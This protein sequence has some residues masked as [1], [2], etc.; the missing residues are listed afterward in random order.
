MAQSTESVGPWPDFMM[1]S[2]SIAAAEAEGDT[3]SYFGS[4]TRMLLVAFPVDSDTPFRIKPTIPPV[5]S[6]EKAALVLVVQVGTSPVLVLDVRSPAGLDDPS[7]RQEADEQSRQRLKALALA[8]DIPVLH[9][10]S[11]FGTKMAFYQYARD[12][13][14][15]EPSV[16]T[17]EPALATDSAPGR[18]WWAFDILEAEGAQKFQ[19]VV[20]EVKAMG[21]NIPTFTNVINIEGKQYCFRDTLN[22]KKAA[23]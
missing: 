9:G 11:V 5:N 18:E 6:L 15:V 4:W 16:S 23:W 2:F 13:D 12:T 17:P 3:Q 14:R 22:Q 8:L 20:N 10:V 1:H 7:K 19:D 21:S